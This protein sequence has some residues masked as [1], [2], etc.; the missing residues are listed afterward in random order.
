MIELARDDAPERMS[1][2]DFLAWEEAQ[3][4]RH[5]RVGGQ[6]WAMTGGTLGHNTVA[7]NVAYALRQRLADTPCSVF[8]MDVWVV[9]PRGDVMYP[10]VVVVCGEHRPTDKEV[11]GPVLVVEVLSPSTAEGEDSFKRWAYGTI[12]SLKHYILIAQD[13][14]LLSRRYR[15]REPGGWRRLSTFGA[16]LRNGQPRPL[17]AHGA[18]HIAA[19]AAKTRGLI[20]GVIRRVRARR[21]SYVCWLLARCAMMF[22]DVHCRRAADAQGPH[23]RQG[24]L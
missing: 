18:L 6:V 12:P 21:R 7:L 11:S 10:D 17:K 19:Y 2:P 22:L 15:R 3:P 16:R 5:E 13:R 9:T 20:A 8:A 4:L 24:G 23:R 1:L 14:G